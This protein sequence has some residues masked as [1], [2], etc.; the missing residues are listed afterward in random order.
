MTRLP[1]M[2][3]RLSVG[4]SLLFAVVL[5]CLLS[6]SLV[7][8]EPEPDPAE[9]GGLVLRGK[10]VAEAMPAMRL[11]TDISAKISGQ[12][13]RITVTQ[14]FRNTSDQWMEATYLYPLPDNGAVDSLRMVVG[15]R[16]FIG[17]IKTRE[18]ARETYEKAK[19]EGRKA[20][21]VEQARANMFRNTIANVGPG[22]TVLVQIEFQTPV[23]QLGGDYALRLPL[24][25]GERYVPPHTLDSGKAVA[26]AQDVTA[27]LAHPRLGNG[28]NPVTISVELAPGFEPENITSPYHKIMVQ[29]MAGNSRMVTLAK[30]ETPANRDFELRWS[31]PGKAPA[32]A[33]FKQRFNGLDYVMAAIT[34]PSAGPVGNIPPREMI[35]VIDNSGSMG[36][37]S[38]RAAKASLLYA[39]GTLRPQDTFNIIRFDDT[40]TVL[41]EEAVPATPD[42]VDF[43]RRYT[44]GLDAAGG[45]EMLPALNAALS[46]RRPADASAIRQ[47]IFLTD[48]NLSNEREM[49]EVINSSL[50]RSRVFMVGIGSAPNNYLMNRMAETGRGTY[51]NIGDGDEVDAQ[52]RKLLDRLSAPV[53]TD[54]KVSVDGTNVDFA[55]RILPDLYAG[56]PLV[57]LARAKE[58]KGRITVSGTLGGK[59]WSQTLKLG[60]ATTSDA[61]ARLWANRRI[62]DLEAQRWAN[63]IDD[64]IADAAIEELGLDFHIVTRRTSLIAEDD[65]P[66]R[67]EGATLTREELPLL[68][69]AGWDFDALFANQGMHDATAA[70]KGQAEL[71][72]ALQLPDTATG[73]M[74]LL[75]R[76]LA[77][78]GLGFGTLAMA[79]RRRGKR[80]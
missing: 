45:T 11:G 46:D 47:V 2:R 19:A 33:L 29:K 31:A 64:A 37:E 1:E 69:P 20:G 55:P 35:F 51:T 52:M 42:Q 32:F 62:A 10:G 50:G 79:R 73:F 21:L 26:D 7:A 4:L 22:E 38:M 56:E 8:R 17:K 67:P 34:P 13:A 3:H 66:S 25:V 75:L 60:D 74:A 30:G 48:G 80:A 9:G 16:I 36:G 68:L 71:Q 44:Q 58:L 77:L 12:T 41:F 40:M 43:A 78:L 39:L 70:A 63:E 27:P 57:L 28:L 6:A 18:E 65:T 49:M 59:P 72:Q 76:G 24:V 5:A 61:V 53:A 23:R 14:A 15:Q 54:L